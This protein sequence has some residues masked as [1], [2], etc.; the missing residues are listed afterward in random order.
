MPSVLSFEQILLPLLSAFFYR[1]WDRQFEMDVKRI[2]S[3]YDYVIVG[4]GSAG[5]V[6]ANRLSDDHLIKVL[7]LEAGGLP[8][9]M[10]EV[11]LFAG[12][13]QESKYDW[14]YSTEPQTT[15]CLG[16]VDRR[17]KWPRGKGLGGS[18]LINYML[19]VRGNS[20]DYDN[21]AQQGA[22]GWSWEDV[23]PYFLKSEDN[24]N[25]EIA[26][27]GYH[28][29]GGLLTVETPNYISPLGHSFVEG[30]KTLGYPNIDINGP[31][32]TGFTVPQGTVRNG[33]RCST[34]KA[35]LQDILN[36][37]N[38]KILINAQVTKIHI[39]NHRR[40]RAVQFDYE[41]LSRVVFARKEII[42]AAGSINT[43]QLLMLS[44]IG[45]R[46][47]LESFGLP[48]IADLPVGLNLQDHVGSAGAHFLIDKPYSVILPRYKNSGLIHDFLLK[49]EGP[50][51]ILGGCEGLGFI[52]TKYTNSSE[53]FPDAEIHFISSSPSSDGG[54]TIRKVQ[55]IGPELWK[56]VYEPYLYRDSF[57]M[58]PVLLRPKSRGYVKLRS[59]D[60]YNPPIIDPH[61]LTHPDDIQTLREALKISIKV[62]LSEPFKAFNTTLFEPSFPGCEKHQMWG[63][64]YLECV[65]R[66]Y[67]VTIY[68]PVGTCKMGDPSDPTTVVDSKLRVKGIKNL[69][70]ADASIMPTIVSGNTN[71]PVIMIGEKAADIIRGIK[72]NE[73]RDNK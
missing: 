19:Y 27:N 50:Y 1:A 66:T 9:V 68:H 54:R 37:P 18:S 33:A 28:G 10:T 60:P 2:R 13:L 35:F 72:P 16:Q 63:D 59:T 15:A 47:H 14:G 71:A 31:A 12:E 38:L 55:G 44:G 58:Y 49:G 51:T 3:E 52:K 65:A 32:Q 25:P 64:D 61:Y 22:Y 43:P 67:S 30:G 42:L 48:V 40:A 8:D 57:S 56:Q 17:S 70:V 39:D 24:R 34:S 41:G 29:R 20:R 69:R 26:Y 7:L 4:A 21:W 46:K 6:L 23:F 62:G 5:A 11:P 45:P 73:L 53:D 36:R